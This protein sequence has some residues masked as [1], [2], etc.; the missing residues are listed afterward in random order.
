MSTSKYVYSL[1]RIDESLDCSNGV[2]WFL[3]LDLKS[4]YWQV[5]LTEEG[6]PLTIFTVGSLDSFK[7]GQMSFRL[8]NMPATL[9]R[10]LKNCLGNLH[11]NWCIIY[12]GDI[13]IFSELFSNIYRD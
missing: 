13:V 2:Q 12:L 5:E 7:C 8:M 11:L 10:L 6:K 1:P 3:S 4:G 9:Q